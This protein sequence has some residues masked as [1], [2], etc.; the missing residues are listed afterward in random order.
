MTK[1]QKQRIAILFPEQVHPGKVGG[2]HILVHLAP[3]LSARGYEIKVFSLG[4]EAQEISEGR[5]EEEVVQS[6]VSSDSRTPSVRALDYLSLAAFGS[7]Y[8]YYIMNNS[9]ELEEAL[10]EYAPDSIITLGRL[11][12][13]FILRYKS[14]HDTLCIAITDDFRVVENSLKIRLEASARRDNPLKRSA[15]SFGSARFHDFSWGVYSRMVNGFDAIALLT[16]AD[17]RLALSRFRG[18]SGKLFV[19][20]AASCPPEYLLKKPARRPARKISTILFIG[21]ARHEPNLQAMEIIEQRIA[22]RLKNKRFIIVGSGMGAHIVGN[23]EY[24]GFVSEEEKFRIIDEADLCIAPLMKGSGIK[25]KMLDYFMRC[26]PVLASSLAFEGYA[27]KDNVNGVVEDSPDGYVTQ[28]LRLERDPELRNTLGLNA[29]RLC[30]YF[31]Y[32][33]IGDKWDALLTK[34]AKRGNNGK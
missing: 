3:I 15:V 21:N 6:N 11:L 25:V 22:P 9:R 27:V 30:A 13:D 33:A 8:S 1:P 4:R 12:T 14:T 31:S 26:K 7:Q 32:D 18:A 2:T 20:P 17:K 29:G 23:V 24:K 19:V 28:I 16:D 10:D 34:L 5:Y